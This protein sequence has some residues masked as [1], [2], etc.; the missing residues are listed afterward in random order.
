MPNLGLGTQN[1]GDKLSI[2]VLDEPDD[3]AVP[4]LPD[5]AIVIVVVQAFCGD[6]MTGRF[7]EYPLTG[8]DHVGQLQHDHL[9]QV[10]GDL[11]QVLFE[12]RKALAA[13]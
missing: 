4:Y 5:Q 7:G 12:S 2:A 13:T 3:L 8:D 1:R 10:R 11:S 6:T 9:T